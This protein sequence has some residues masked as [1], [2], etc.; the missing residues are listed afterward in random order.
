M[1]D[2]L[3]WWTHFTR[4]VTVVARELTVSDWF[5]PDFTPRNK[6]L[7]K[8]EK[9]RGP[10]RKML[11]FLDNFTELAQRPSLQPPTVMLTL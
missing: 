4:V 7:D 3:S 5:S 11:S 9:K 1:S 6:T 2:G 10:R 8:P